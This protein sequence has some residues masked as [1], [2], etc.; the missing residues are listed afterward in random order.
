[1][2]TATASNSPLVSTAMCRLRPLVFLPASYPRLDRGTVSEPCTDWESMIAADGSGVRPSRTRVRS[3]SAS[4]MRC[5]T[6][7]R[8]QRAKIA[9][10]VVAGGNST[11]SCRQAMPPRT[12]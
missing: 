7:A 3:R 12:T 8:T 4:W 9:H 6:P 5:H 10:T 11:G 1:M 2:V